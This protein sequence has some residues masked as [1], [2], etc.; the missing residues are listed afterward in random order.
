MDDVLR[1]AESFSRQGKTVLI[2]YDIDNTLLAADQTLGS[3]PW[4]DA[5]VAS[6]L[7]LN[8]PSTQDLFHLRLQTQL[9]DGVYDD[10]VEAIADENKSHLV[11]GA[12]AGEI[13]DLQRKPGVKMIILTSRDG[14]VSGSTDRALK[15]NGLDFAGSKFGQD[16]SV[17]TVPGCPKPGSYQD[18]IFSTYGSNKGLMLTA[19]LQAQKFAPDVVLY[20]DNKQSEVD[21]VYGAL[22]DANVNIIAYRYSR[23]DDE[24]KAYQARPDH[25][26]ARV[27]LKAWK[28]SGHILSDAEAQVVIDRDPG[29]DPVP[30]SEAN[31]LIYGTENPFAP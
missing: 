8:Q 20:V 15:E 10:L 31:M 6:L 29:H 28:E 9:L 14:R 12:V 21:R 1:Q 17:F 2:A 22:K 7:P 24:A 25:P 11:D 18:G 5:M 4:V 19:M 26:E 16:M 23:M 3:E 13:R 30:A 27:E